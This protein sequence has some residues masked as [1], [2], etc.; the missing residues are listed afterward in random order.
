MSM[1]LSEFLDV[2]LE[3]CFEGLEAMESGL[4]NLDESTDLEEVNT[5][6]R[7]AHSIKGGSAA[8]GFNHISEFTHVMETLLD[9]LRSGKRRVDQATVDLLLSA[10]ERRRARRGKGGRA[11]GPARSCGEG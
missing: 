11:Q 2:F 1:D 8:F 7:A 5:I 6:F 10:Q 9:Q 3:E 4:L